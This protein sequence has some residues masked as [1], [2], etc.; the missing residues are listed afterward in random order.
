[1]LSA[2]RIYCKITESWRLQSVVSLSL[3]NVAAPLYH[4]LSVA[5][6]FLLVSLSHALGQYSD[7]RT[8]NFLFRSSLHQVQPAPAPQMRVPAAS[9]S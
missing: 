8:K 1:L 7:T 6:N 2:E 3:E 9:G 4:K 5:L